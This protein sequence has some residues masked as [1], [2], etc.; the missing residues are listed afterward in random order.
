MKKF[1]F[2]VAAAIAMVSCN[3]VDEVKTSGVQENGMI[4]LT[5]SINSSDEVTR[6]Q[7]GA[8][9]QDQLFVVG[10][11]IKVEVYATSASTP[12]DSGIYTTAAQ[13]ALNAKTTSDR[14]FYP[15]NN[16]NVDLCAY[17]PSE[18]SS[19]SEAFAIENDQREVEKYQSSDLMYATK[20]TN[21]ASMENNVP[22]THN[23]VFN[24]ALTKIV[25]NI[26]AGDGLVAS[27][28][29]E[30][31]GVTEVKINNTILSATLAIDGGVITASAAN[32]PAA[33]INITGTGDNHVGIIVPQ[34]LNAETTF[35]SLKY[36]NVTYTYALSSQTNFLAGK[37]Y[38]YNLTL[39]ARGLVLQSTQITPWD[40]QT[41][42]SQGITI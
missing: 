12:Y 39:S 32:V 38:T 16:G 9:L 33:D 23:L 24:H 27:N 35:I 19:G 4:N 34:T 14:L 8:S 11:D 13:G 42:G 29:T 36:N 22:I 15:A 21:C 2:L 6:A 41:G 37:Q 7:S 10:K 31:P 3:N 17:Y 26:A 5:A 30:T 1:I 18:I 20:L 25:V 28:I 40:P